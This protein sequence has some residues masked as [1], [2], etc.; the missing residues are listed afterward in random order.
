MYI[1]LG[2]GIAIYRQNHTK[3][4]YARLRID[5]KEIRRTLSTSDIEEAK[6]KAWHLRFDLE[7]KAAL[8]VPIY[9]NK[10][11]S[12]ADA[13]HAVIYRINLKMQA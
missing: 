8:G 3:S 5:K 13:C 9:Q 12:I 2:K 10:I 7:K 1:N 6:A 4:I 11:L